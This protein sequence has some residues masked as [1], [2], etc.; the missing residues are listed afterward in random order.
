ME[1][2]VGGE[3]RSVRIKEEENEGEGR[4]E[5]VYAPK[6]EELQRGIGKK[7]FCDKEQ[8]RKKTKG[9]RGRG[10]RRETEGKGV[11]WRSR[12]DGKTRGITEIRERAGEEDTRGGI[13]WVKLE[14]NGS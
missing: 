1:T 11:E 5:G 10:E 8:E 2:K 14:E 9:G 12:M 13:A 7:E 3:R 4:V 6:K